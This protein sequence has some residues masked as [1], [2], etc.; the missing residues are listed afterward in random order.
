MQSKH[1]EQQLYTLAASLG[2]CSGC[3]TDPGRL[4][5]SASFNDATVKIKGRVEAVTCQGE[6]LS[7]NIVDVLGQK[8]LCKQHNTISTP[9]AAVHNGSDLLSI[10]VTS[11]RTSSTPRTSVRMRVAALDVTVDPIFLAAFAAF[12]EVHHASRYDRPHSSRSS[13]G[14]YGN[15]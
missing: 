12:W 4:D 2:R 3:V 14:V 7:L 8:P 5:M 13:A 15:P 9:S 11:D 10:D 1:P 6:L